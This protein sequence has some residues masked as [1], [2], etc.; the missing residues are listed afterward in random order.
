MSTNVTKMRVKGVT[1]TLNGKLYDTTGSHTDGSMTQASITEE[2]NDAREY[3]ESAYAL[4]EQVREEGKTVIEGNVSNNPDEE[5]LTSVVNEQTGLGEL[6]LKDRTYVPVE[7]T[8]GYVILRKETSLALQM[9]KENTIYEIRYN[10]DLNGDTLTVPSGCV[11][12]FNGGKISNGVIVGNN[13]VID[14]PLVQIF[15]NIEFSGTYLLNEIPITWFGAKT[16]DETY[17][18]SPC[19]KS[20]I[21]LSNL[22]N[23]PV[24]IPAGRFYCLTPIEFQHSTTITVNMI[25]E[26]APHD[27]QQSSASLNCS[28]IQILG[29]DN[30]GFICS[31]SDNGTEYIIIVGSIRYIYFLGNIYNENSHLFYNCIFRKVKFIDNSAGGFRSILYGRAVNC[32]NFVGN[33]F[34]G[35]SHLIEI[36]DSALSTDYAFVDSVIDKN[37]IN[38]RLGANIRRK[39]TIDGKEQISIIPTYFGHLSSMIKGI[40]TH[41]RITNN[42]IDFYKYLFYNDKNYNVSSPFKIPIKD[43]VIFS[44]NLVD[45]CFRFTNEDAT[46]TCGTIVNNTFNYIHAGGATW[47]VAD[48]VSGHPKYNEDTIG[49]EDVCNVA[50]VFFNALSYSNMNICENRFSKTDVVLIGSKFNNCIIKNNTVSS[51]SGDVVKRPYFIKYGQIE[52]TYIDGYDIIKS[53]NG[54]Y[55]YYYHTNIIYNINFNNDKLS[56][57]ISKGLLP[58]VD[59]FKNDSSSKSQ[60]YYRETNSYLSGVKL[61][62]L[63]LNYIDD[64]NYLF[65]VLKDYEDNNGYHFIELSNIDDE[66]IKYVVVSKHNTN[67]EVIIECKSTD[68]DAIIDI[69]QNSNGALKIDTV[70]LSDLGIYISYNSNPNYSYL[71]GDV[72][73]GMFFIAYSYT[74]LKLNYTSLPSTNLF[75][76]RLVRLATT[77]NGTTT[78]SW[79]KYTGSEWVDADNTFYPTKKF[80]SSD[81]RPPKLYCVNNRDLFFDTTINKYI[82]NN[83]TSWTE[84]DGA[85]AGTLR[86]GTFAN[87]PDAADIYTGFEFFC[88]DRQTA[89]GTTDGIMI[90]HKGN[91][92]WVDALGRVIS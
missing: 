80:G 46:I 17:D 86:S 82:Y 59:F 3:A 48:T 68:Y 72:I 64:N 42:Y 21:L 83:G 78:Y 84:S 5:D 1:Y 20:A 26:G 73:R 88:T 49:D 7:T 74:N 70:L 87:V 52:N 44:H 35:N 13:T 57:T 91:N 62:T 63:T 61:G 69:V 31:D 10:F 34:I 12:K 90:Y 24:K 47:S 58:T 11:L 16:N 81:E 29:W 51:I 37:Y 6:K 79:K 15:D 27:N 56:Y 14:S 2:L 67:N 19:I 39:E 9:T 30:K 45:Y 66:T 77:N 65:D 40:V 25:G 28:H 85:K 41:S 55:D 32:T 92:V 89:E 8:K 4:A 18:N 22:N 75:P 54:N 38:G 76:N 43:N 23:V 60:T 33:R 53:K 36:P 50:W 71:K